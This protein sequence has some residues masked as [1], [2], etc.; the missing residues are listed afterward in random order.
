VYVKTNAQKQTDNKYIFHIECDI[1]L[2]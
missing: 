1:I 2:F